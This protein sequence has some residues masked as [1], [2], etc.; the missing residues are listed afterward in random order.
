MLTR[1]GPPRRY[2]TPFAGGSALTRPSGSGSV[3]ESGVRKNGDGSGLPEW[4]WYS[5]WAQAGPREN[6]LG[7]SD[8][9][10]EQRGPIQSALHFGTTTNTAQVGY[11][12]RLKPRPPEAEASAGRPPGGSCRAMTGGAFTALHRPGQR[13]TERPG[14]CKAKF[15]NLIGPHFWLPI[16]SV[17]PF[18]SLPCSLR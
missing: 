5:D 3:S 4:A 11:I 6:P 1:T 14:K 8:T 13:A 7:R 9:D 16:K 15:P 2:A 18:T 10:P 17:F 12:H